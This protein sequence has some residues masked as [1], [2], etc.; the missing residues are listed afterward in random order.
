MRNPPLQI[1]MAWGMDL[2]L[3][4]SEVFFHLRPVDGV[5]PGLEIIG[6][7]VLI[8]QV[9]SMFPDVHAEESLAAVDDGIVL[10]RGGFDDEFSV[11]E[12][13]PGPARAEALDAR[14]VDFRLEVREAAECGADGFAE[15]AARFAASAFL[16][17]L[18]EQGMVQV[19]AAIVAHGGAN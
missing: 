17:D 10:V 4:V 15:L 16:H 6:P 11:P 13:Q 3:G 9:I 2:F 1:A 14:I 7:P 8:F 5:P 18:P 19:A 12:Q